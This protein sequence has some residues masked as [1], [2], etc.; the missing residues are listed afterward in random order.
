MYLYLGQD[1]VINTSDMIGIFDLENTSTSR[2]TR[3]YLKKAQR[4]G[5]IIEVSQD[6]PKSFVVCER[7]GK[8]CVYLSQ[9]SPATLR[10]RAY[11][12]KDIANL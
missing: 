4:G 5:H 1:T 11:Y 8:I 12:I 3:S 9:I 10:K 6:I 7:S 2:I